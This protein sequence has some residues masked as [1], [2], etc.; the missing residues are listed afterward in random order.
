MN[1]LIKIASTVIF[2]F[3]FYNVLAQPI[4]LI[5]LD[6]GHFHAAL[7]QKSMYS[8]ID[9]V[10]HVYSK[11]GSDLQLHLERINNYNSR[12]SEPTSW[13]EI[14]YTGDDFFKRMIQDKKGNLVVLAGNNQL[15]TNYILESVQNGLHVLSDK[16][17][18]IDQ[19]GFKKLKKAFAIAEQKNVQLYDI[20][21]ERFEITSQLQRAISMDSSIFGK[22]EQGST[23]DPSV[24]KE[25]VHHFY[26]FVSGSVLTRPS[27]YFDDKQ[28]G[29]G[30][31]D[32]TT[33]L[34]DLIQWSCFPEK[35]ID[36]KKHIQIL[37]AKEWATALTQ[38]EFKAVTKSEVVPSFL[39][40][41]IDQ[42]GNIQVNSN[43]EFT[44]SI[45]GT[46]AKVAVTW[47]Y[48]APD[49]TG[50]T[51]YSLMR[52]TKSALI[53][54]QGAEEKYKPTLYIQQR[55]QDPTFETKLQIA[56]SKIN[57]S[58]PGVS[59][60]KNKNEWQLIVPE[61]YNDGH[62][63]HFAQVMSKYLNYLQ[64]NNMPDWEVPNMLSK[65]Y[66]TTSAKSLASKKKPNLK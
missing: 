13:K 65:Y 45:N 15:K 17:M 20:M 35:T 61:K 47:N 32:V 34:V 29:A 14:L 19:S 26:K 18:A 59:L 6:P 9:P 64:Y 52:G 12:V 10:V 39:T 27:W 51:H 1:L 63:A 33:H 8:E 36:Y 55:D 43:G 4:K 57:E 3:S 58:F 40:R 7:V 41:S 66:I 22:L 54:R 62:E 16:P 44:F 2:S 49:G 37:N 60:K 53:I 48:K 24:I 30:I 38:D 21:T 42:Q 5:T 46:H 31:V 11:A 28:Q 50:D 23:T 25:S 56:I